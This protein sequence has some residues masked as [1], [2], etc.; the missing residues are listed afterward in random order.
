MTGAAF[1]QALAVHDAAQ[2]RLVDF[3][4]SRGWAIEVPPYEVEDTYRPDAR[5]SG[6]RTWIDFKLGHTLDVRELNDHLRRCANGDTILYLL[7]CAN[8][9]FLPCVVRCDPRLL[10]DAYTESVRLPRK[11]DLGRRV[12]HPFLCELMVRRFS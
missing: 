5:I 7:G 8:E 4:R 11:Q 9:R 12:N 1:R 3:M 2:D 10:S 6:T